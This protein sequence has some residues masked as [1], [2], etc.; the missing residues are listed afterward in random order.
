MHWLFQGERPTGVWWDGDFAAQLM[1]RDSASF[2]ALVVDDLPIHR[3]L[4][5]G[6]MRLLFPF[7]SVDV[8][9]GGRRAQAMLREHDYDIVLSDWV[10]PGMDGLQLAKWLHSGEVP[11]RSFVLFSAHDEIAEIERLFSSHG[12]AGCLIKPLDQEAMMAVISAA[13]GGVAGAA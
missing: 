5:S 7:A 2:K 4:M 3:A 8:A 12:I 13:L 1:A 6:M 10:M 9:E 11:P